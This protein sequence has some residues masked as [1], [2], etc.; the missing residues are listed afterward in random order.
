MTAAKLKR[1]TN[2]LDLLADDTRTADIASVLRVPGTL[3]FKYIPPRPV[4]LKHA[5]PS[6]IDSSAMLAAIDAA[7]EMVCK[8]AASMSPRRLP[9]DLSQEIGDNAV[10][11]GPPDLARFGPPDL[12]RLASAL[13]TLDPDCAE[14][15]WTLKRLAP[16][17]NLARHCPELGEELYQLA[18]SWSSGALRGTASKAWVT[19]GSNGRTGED[20][21]DEVWHRFLN[22]NYSGTPITIRTVY[23]DA[24]EV[25]WCDRDEAFESIQ[26]EC[27]EDA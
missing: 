2:A 4:T 3:N 12:A 21:F 14:P 9:R 19:P 20:V 22:G 27:G 25:G 10:R 13:A 1:L 5:S 18:R 7:H 15:T 16:L 17:A 11:F 23:F 8:P 24:R 26:S 6:P